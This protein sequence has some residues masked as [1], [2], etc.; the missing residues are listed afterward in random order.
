MAGI[1]ISNIMAGITIINR[2]KNYMVGRK[3]QESGIIWMEQMK[4]IRA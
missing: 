1:L 3:Y 4:S 2:E